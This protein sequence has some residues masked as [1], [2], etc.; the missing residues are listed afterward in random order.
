MINQ[1]E[2]LYPSL[3]NHP[4]S[5]F[6]QLNGMHIKLTAH[7]IDIIRNNKIVRISLKHL[8]YASDIIK[9]FEY[10]FNSVTPYLFAGVELVDY[11]SPRW[12]EVI[13]FDLHPIFFNSFSEPVITTNQYLGFA[14]LKPG[15]TVLDL[16]A[17]SGL[18]SIIFKQIVGSSGRVV[19]VDADSENIRAIKTNLNLYRKVTSNNIDL[20]FGA[21]WNHSDGLSFSTEGNMGSSAAE[22]VGTQRGSIDFIRS[23]TLSEICNTEKIDCLDFI[24]CDIEGA[25]AVI[26]EDEIFL[27][28]HLP[29]IIIEPHL[30]DG[31]E[32][33]EKCIADLSKFGYKCKKTVQVGV[34]LPLLECYPPA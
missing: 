15:H 14:D 13:G 12:H 11:S 9:S 30:K 7:Y 31:V 8:I 4:L 3:V 10:Y 29:K 6:A 19:A 1:L 23:F 32:T 25:E 17:Y 16:G 26:F 24:K 27:R 22:I 34:S 33:T 18:T 2:K 5:E 21:V 28:N 20:L